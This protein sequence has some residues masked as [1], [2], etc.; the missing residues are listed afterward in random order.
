MSASWETSPIND[1]LEKYRQDSME[2]HDTVSIDLNDRTEWLPDCLV[3]NP[4]NR[5]GV[6]PPVHNKFDPLHGDWQQ[7]HKDRRDD[8]APISSE[9][10]PTLNATKAGESKSSCEFNQAFV[11][12][13]ATMRNSRAKLYPRNPEKPCPSTPDSKA[14]EDE[15]QGQGDHRTNAQGQRFFESTESWGVNN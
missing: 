1:G 9:Y 11:D 5:D 2:Y 14:T 4:H 12:A 8:M 10:S 7:S 6:A 3:E 15:G 13:I